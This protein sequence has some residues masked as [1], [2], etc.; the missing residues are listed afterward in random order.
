MNI[1][2]YNNSIDFLKSILII[3][4]VIGHSIS[5]DIRLHRYIFWFHMPAFFIVSGYL[6]NWGKY[7]LSEFIKKKFNSY[8]IPYL[9]WSVL[10][11]FIYIP[12]NP[13]KNIVRVLY[14]GSINTLIYSY[15]YW[16]INCIYISVIIFK[17]LYERL[18]IKQITF[19]IL[20]MW[21]LFHYLISYLS[22]LPWSLEIMPFAIFY[23]YIGFLYKNI[24]HKQF[25]YMYIICIITTICLFY[26][27]SITDIK[28]E[29]NMKSGILR[30]PILDIIY[31]SIIT[32]SL[33]LTCKYIKIRLFN[34]IG[35]A[36]MTIMF[37]HAPLINLVQKTFIPIY[38]YIPFIIF[39]STGIHYILNK[40]RI[41][42]KLFIGK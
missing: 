26:I 5:S 24:E 40:N 21:F 17:F 1:S 37:I 31:P 23:I 33:Y 28:Y 36:S 20:F 16:F 8:I 38:I 6:N 32:L 19:I 35:N 18:N 34:T 25:K 30:H 11:Y 22:P 10:F 2:R 12:E 13:I 39:L 42:Q 27:D 7:T 29:I 9:S 14:G 3:L 41:T 4:M 15:P